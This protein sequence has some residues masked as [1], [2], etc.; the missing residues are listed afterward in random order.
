MKRRIGLRLLVGPVN[1][2]IKSE[3]GLS[4]EGLEKSFR[5]GLGSVLFNEP[6]N[7]TQAQRDF[8]LL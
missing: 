2:R 5:T 1:P 4:R 7:I 6:V 8:G 3:E